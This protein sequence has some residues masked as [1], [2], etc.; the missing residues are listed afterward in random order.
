MSLSWI[1]AAEFVAFVDALSSLV[2]FTSLVAQY[3]N[4]LLVSL[5]WIVAAEFVVFILPVTQYP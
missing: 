1:V 4:L 5:I 2:V 3:L